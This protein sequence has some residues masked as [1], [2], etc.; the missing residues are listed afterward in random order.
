VARVEVSRKLLALLESRTD[1]SL[2]NV[3]TRDEKSIYLDNLWTSMRIG[4]M[5]RGQLEFGTL[6]SRKR[7]FWIDFSRTA[8]DAVVMLP[9]QESFNK[10]FFPGTVLPHV[11]ED[12]E[13]TRPKLKAHGTFLHLDNAP[14]HLI[15][16]KYDEYGIKRP[17]HRPYSPDLAP[18]DFW[19]FDDLKQSLEGR[20]VDD[21]LALEIAVSEIL[22]SIEPDVL[23]R[24]F[25]ERKRR[26]QQCIDQGGDYLK[27]ADLHCSL[28]DP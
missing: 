12:R 2:F 21:D 14:P 25:A 13:L 10:D 27:P 23:V 8:I 19:L 1:R 11:V 9:S 20:F 16:E 3:Y 15:P 22:M 18:C 26:L 24:V 28:S 6:G 4:P 7:M 5:L 17:P